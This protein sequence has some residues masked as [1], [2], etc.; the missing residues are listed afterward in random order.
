VNSSAALDITALKPH[1]KLARRG[2]VRCCHEIPQIVLLVIEKK[3]LKTHTQMQATKDQAEMIAEGGGGM[4]I[5]THTHTHTHTVLFYVETHTD[6]HTHTEF[7][8]T[9]WLPTV[10]SP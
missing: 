9:S 6:T 3:L 5:H 7:E 8:S 1:Y 2:E 10:C 4:N